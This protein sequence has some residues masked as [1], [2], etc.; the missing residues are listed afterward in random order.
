MREH[1]NALRGAF[2]GILMSIPLWAI[3]VM[4]AILL[5]SSARADDDF[6]SV[7][8]VDVALEVMA[9]TCQYLDE[10][11][12]DNFYENV[13]T[14]AAANIGLATMYDIKYEDAAEVIG[15]V[16]TNFCPKHLDAL[17]EYR[18]YGDKPIDSYPVVLR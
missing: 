5:A 17:K 7:D 6:T 10:Y 11:I 9:G 1:D 8:K 16:I 3:I 12:T 15:F 2:W 13:N 14:F 4:L 18:D